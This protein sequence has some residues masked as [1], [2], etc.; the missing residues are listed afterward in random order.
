MRASR[1]FVVGL[2][3]LVAVVHVASFLSPPMP[4]IHGDGTYTYY[5]ARSLAFDGDL[6]LRNDY[7]LCGDPWGRATPVRE[8]L[9]PSNLWSPG[10]ALIWAPLLLVG[11]LV[12]P[13]ADAPQPEIAG[14]CPTSRLAKLAMG[15][16]VLAG[17][18]AVWLTYRLGRRH[19]GPVAGA[20]GAAA[21]G[22]AT[23]LP[24]YAT[25]L[26]S[27]A[28]A[29][30]AL[31]AALFVE[32][33]DATRGDRRL[34]RWAGIGLL[35]GVTMSVR[36]QCATLA[37]APLL[38]WIGGARRSSG[39]RD[40][41]RWIA[42]GLVSVAAALVGF[43][44]QMAAWKIT[45]GSVLA[46]P[47]GSHFMRWHVPALDGVLFASS[48]G[49]LVWT[50]VLY[51]ALAGLGIAAADRRTRA[52]GL[53]L[54][55][56]FLSFVYV[57]GAVW[58]WWGAA[59]FGARRFTA[60]SAVFGLGLAVFAGWLLRLADA[61]PRAFAAGALS[62]GLALFTAWNYA[63]MWVIA[64]AAI[65]AHEEGRSDRFALR[66]FD[67]LAA[68]TWYA[69]GNP[70]TWPASIP[71]ALRYG[72]H[73]RRYDLLRG[74]GFLYRDYQEFQLRPG[75]DRVVLSR[76]PGI[77]LAARGFA[78]TATSPS[79]SRGAALRMVADEAAVL[80]PLF[81]GDLR[82]LTIQWRRARGPDSPVDEA[83]EDVR[84]VLNGVALGAVG[85]PRI[86]GRTALEV[87]PGA[88]RTGI[89]EL[90]LSVSDPGSRVALARLTLG[91]R[92]P[93]ASA[94]P[95]PPSPASPPAPS[96]PPLRPSPPSPRPSAP[97]ASPGAAPALP[98]FEAS[99]ARPRSP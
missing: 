78:E 76:E 63:A 75:D 67:E 98:R 42:A 31:A 19:A 83:V 24:Y 58:D 7:E 84:V 93:G 87:P 46:V 29:P 53:P 64:K 89:N 80:L 88:A 5:W 50:P 40:L 45:Y 35:L 86:L 71:F 92:P 6:D 68:D 26:P 69:I 65:P 56:V 17:L 95:S 32:R 97:G 21:V 82:A 90:V 27:Y 55:L 47:Q 1:A 36:A 44:P 72:T 49:L 38:E 96:S 3:S 8:G 99:P 30:A 11:R 10:P 66:I 85:A 4:P 16:S 12:H 41:G 48:G 33:W 2:L 51:L 28:H 9:G 34:W 25:L 37:L 54:G 22:L 39:M 57:N 81:A 61:R 94:S 91:R 15:G 13:D 52:V 62:V 73:P 70:L 18:L 77:H 74:E 14:G 60:L 20:L 79:P 23:T 43:S 59:S